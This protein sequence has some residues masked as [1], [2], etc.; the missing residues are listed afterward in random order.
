M[1]LFNFFNR[2]NGSAN[3]MDSTDAAA[4]KPSENPQD[5]FFE[6][7][8]TLNGASAPSHNTVSSQEGISLLFQFLEKNYEKKGYDDALINPDNTHLEQNIAALKN[9]LQ[10]TIRKVKTFYEDF[11]REINFHITSRSR[12]GM[13]DTVEELNAKKETAESH[14]RHVLEIEQEANESR[15]VA[16]GIVLSYTRGFKNGLAAISHHSIMNRNF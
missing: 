15:G 6:K 3:H 9:E 10:R 8:K 16:Q 2:R 14:V 12:S 13:V 7:D 5:V 11:I 1:A 4:Q